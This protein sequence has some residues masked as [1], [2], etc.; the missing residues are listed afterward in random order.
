MAYDHFEFQSYIRRDTRETFHTRIL[1]TKS[2]FQ[3]EHVYQ[4]NGG[5]LTRTQWDSIRHGP[6][7]LL[8]HLDQSSLHRFVIGLDY[9]G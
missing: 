1:L 4:L 8:M 6:Y 5:T 9:S 7:A 3:F 2:I